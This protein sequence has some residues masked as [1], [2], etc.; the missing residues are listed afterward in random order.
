ME[1]LFT[2][3]SQAVAGADGL[4]LA[5]AFAWGVCSIL[6]SPCHLASLPLIVG[7]IGA[8]ERMTVRQAFATALLFAVGILATIAGIG[9]VTAAAGR[10][11]GDVGRWSS[12][13]VAVVFVMTGLCLLGVIRLPFGRADPAGMTRKGLLAA[14]TLGLVFGVALGPCTFAFLAP[15]LAVTFKLAATRPA[16]GLLLLAAFAA[17]HCSVIV[18]AGTGT[19]LVRRYLAWTGQSSG[20]RLLRRACGLLVLL[21][22]LYMILATR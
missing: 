12:V 18:A 6:L 20:A 10:L 5:A 3:L 2:T 17:G 1:H 19:G 15:M 22:G 21:V 14:L 16:S 4:A 13:A 8:Q 7:F 11:M 9:A